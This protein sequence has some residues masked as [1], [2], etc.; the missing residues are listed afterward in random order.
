MP[1]TVG[2]LTSLIIWTGTSCRCFAVLQER[3]DILTFCLLKYL[4]AF[5]FLARFRMILGGND[6]GLLRG[7]VNFQKA[8]C[9]LDASIKIYSYRVDETI[10]STYRVLENLSRTDASGDLMEDGERDENIEVGGSMGRRRAV[11]RCLQ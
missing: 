7:Q 10:A 5:L 11:Q 4:I 9:T 8:S 2:V 1:R 3:K 6:A